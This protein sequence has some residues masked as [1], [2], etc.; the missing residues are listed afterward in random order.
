MTIKK[1]IFC[2]KCKKILSSN[3]KTGLC[4]HCYQ[5]IKRKEFRL[6]RRKK[7]VCLDCGKEIELIKP[8]RC[9]LCRERQNKYKKII[10]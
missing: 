2:S 6:N 7:G 10:I 4:R 5:Y 8:V 1:Q 9:N 3:N